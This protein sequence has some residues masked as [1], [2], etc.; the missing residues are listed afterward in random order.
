MELDTGTDANV[1][2]SRSEGESVMIDELIDN[3][4]LQ[5]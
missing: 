1:R 2:S 5:A 4:E 3:V